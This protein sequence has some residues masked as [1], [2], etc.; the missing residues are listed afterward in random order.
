MPL[1]QSL[2][3]PYL[4]YLLSAIPIGFGINAMLNPIS[5][6]SWFELPYPT[7]PQD[8]DLINAVLTIYGARDIFMG[9]ALFSAA[10]HGNPRVTG[11][12][13][14]FTGAVAGVDGAICPTMESA[15]NHWGYGPVMAV[16][17]SVLA[18]GL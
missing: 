1:S 3:I 8:Q 5:A 11:W 7:L 18:A 4:A 6:L 2:L 12:M 16:L 13:L 9:A 10:Y 14:V 15:M 17:G